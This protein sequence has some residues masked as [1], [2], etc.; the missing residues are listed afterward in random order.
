[1]NI[2]H[3]SRRA[4]LCLPR[5]SGL[6]RNEKIMR[7][8]V[9]NI[10]RYNQ[11]V[12][13]ALHTERII[14]TYTPE[15]LEQEVWFK[16]QTIGTSRDLILHQY[17]IGDAIEVIQQEIVA[18]LP[19]MVTNSEFVRINGTDNNRNFYAVEDERRGDTAFT[20]LALLLLPQPDHVDL[21]RKLLAPDG[22]RQSY[23]MDVLIKAFVPDHAIQ[24][25]YKADKNAA[26]WMEPVLRIV[27]SAPE[28]RAEG[29]ERHMKNWC[30]IL[31][32]W[33]CKPDLVPRSAK[34]RIFCD[35][36]F[37]VALVVCA[38]DIDDRTFCDHPYYP[39]DLV[40]YYRAHL[41]YTRDAWRAEGVGAG[42]AVSAPPPPKK[43]DLT[44][45]KRK[46]I[47]RWIELVCDGN[48]DV[49]ESVLEV[50]GKPRKLER[51]D[52]LMEALGEENQA[53]HADMK[54]DETALYQAG[55]L[56][57]QRDVGEFDG[58]SGPPFGPARC[59]AGLLAFAHWLQP[60][61][62]CLVDLDNDDDA[63]HAVVV[64]TEY[65]AELIE[66]SNRL[67][68]RARAPDAVYHG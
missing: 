17:G 36:S 3:A 64:K 57:E 22:R 1:M 40:E 55:E 12:M 61:G 20:A 21:F 8:P 46:G 68:I 31:R 32:P 43:A 56:A 4:A 39:R 6:L 29:L 37:E 41:R 65:H 14:T 63:W 27:A 45:S 11:F 7:D 42:V 47:A 50:I 48:I 44:K 9:G 35:F 18:R 30:R 26:I 25:K 51:I 28:E 49:T 13:E 52:A 59:S 23:L 10:D 15:S 67:K 60:R 24:Q 34:D 5:E 53:I 2:I 58:P 33:G 54:D 19:V 62:Y 66:L 16:L 38:Y